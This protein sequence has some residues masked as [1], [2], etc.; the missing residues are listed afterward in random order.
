MGHHSQMP[1]EDL[2][3]DPFE[4]FQEKLQ[5][6]GA[7]GKFSDGKITDNDE[8]EIVIGITEKDGRIIMKFGKQIEWIGFTK[9]QALDIAVSLIQKANV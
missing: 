3:N 7:T 8:G 6:L 2:S 5:Q 4:I 9:Q 1:F